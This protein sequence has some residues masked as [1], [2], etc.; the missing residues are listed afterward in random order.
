MD[1]L[2][3]PSPDCRHPL[4]PATVRD[5]LGAEAFERWEGLLLQRTLDKM[6]DVVYCPRCDSSALLRYF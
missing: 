3:C 6:D 2:K 1:N 4:R 5:L